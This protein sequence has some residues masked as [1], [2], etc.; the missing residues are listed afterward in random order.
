M[1]FRVKIKDIV[2]TPS[3]LNPLKC[4]FRKNW[5]WS[6]RPPKGILV[7]GCDDPNDVYG[8]E[9]KTL[10]LERRP[11]PPLSFNLD[12]GDC[13]TTLKSLILR[14]SILGVQLI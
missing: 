9:V 7:F 12:C 1:S 10:K 11:I 4:F 2:E 8:F 14:A 6:H 13:S 5:L 3:S